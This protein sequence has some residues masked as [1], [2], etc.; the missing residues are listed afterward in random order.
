M[1]QSQLTRTEVVDKQTKKS[2]QLEMVHER[3]VFGFL[4]KVIMMGLLS[5]KVI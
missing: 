3:H 5:N 2:R 1:K 4:F